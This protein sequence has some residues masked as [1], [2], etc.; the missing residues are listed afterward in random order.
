MMSFFNNL[1]SFYTISHLLYLE[2]FP[3]K[4]NRLPPQAAGR[5]MFR[6]IIILVEPF[7]NRSSVEIEDFILRE[8]I[9]SN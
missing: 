3:A 5:Y 9:E 6:E 1:I 2:F 8:K 7:E 4:A